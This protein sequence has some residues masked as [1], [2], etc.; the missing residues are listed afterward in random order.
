[1]AKTISLPQ[2]D[3]YVFRPS[4]QPK[5][6][7]EK[8]QG[9]HLTN[10]EVVLIPDGGDVTPLDEYEKELLNAGM[11]KKHIE[12]IIDGLADSPLYESKTSI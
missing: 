11:S 7:A 4:L 12:E 2:S 6:L 3:T 10:L 5:S 8:T 9:E 1:M